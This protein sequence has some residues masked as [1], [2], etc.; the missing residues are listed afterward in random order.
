MSIQM[1]PLTPAKRAPGPK[2]SLIWGSL[3][4]F[5]K[6]PLG[7]LGSAAREHGDI[8]RLRFGPIVAHLIN[9]PEYIEHVLLRNADKYDKNTRSVGMIKATTGDSLLSSNEDAW[10][11]HRRLI[12]PVFHPQYMQSIGTI[13]DDETKAVMD[14]WLTHAKENKPVEIVSEMMRLVIAISAKVLFAANID[15]GRLE[16]ALEVV[17]ADTWR[18]L[19]SLLDPSMI[20]PILHRRAFKSAVGEID[21]IIYKIIADR[22]RETV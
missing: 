19:E 5:Q 21:D 8:F 15:A 4:E 10:A 2:G 17:L 13:I 14:R 1:Q 11:R 12:Q 6:D 16:V 3:A 9:Q 18:R 22:R 7:L 20:S